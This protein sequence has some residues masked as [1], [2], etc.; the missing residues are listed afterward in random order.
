MCAH[1]ILHSEQRVTRRAR[2]AIR[3]FGFRVHIMSPQSR[4]HAE[5]RDAPARHQKK[6]RTWESELQKLRKG[7]GDRR[8]PIRSPTCCRRTSIAGTCHPGSGRWHWPRSRRRRRTKA[9]WENLPR[10]WKISREAIARRCARP[11]TRLAPSS[12]PPRRS[13]I[14]CWPALSHSTPP[15]KQALVSIAFQLQARGLTQREI[16]EQFGVEHTTV[17]RWLV[18]SATGA[19]CTNDADPLPD[20]A[21]LD[22]IAKAIKD[23]AKGEVRSAAT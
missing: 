15:T 20:K 6:S 8:S 19:E 7:A 14:A 13:P 22:R 16:A 3:A 17:G 1:Q 2:T 9:A 10:F 21:T 11:F 12:A 23:N 18:Q 4:F 5:V